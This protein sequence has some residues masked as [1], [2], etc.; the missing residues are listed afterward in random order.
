MDS[1][2]V[3]GDGISMILLNVGMYVGI[4]AIAIMRMRK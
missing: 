4:P 3:L 2:Q 1:D